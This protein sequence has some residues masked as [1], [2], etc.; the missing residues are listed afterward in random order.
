MVITSALC[1]LDRLKY[2]SKKSKS[3]HSSSTENSTGRYHS[4]RFPCQAI[5]N[6]AHWNLLNTGLCVSRNLLWYLLVASK[7]YTYIYHTINTCSFTV[8]VF[9]CK[10]TGWQC[11]YVCVQENSTLQLQWRPSQMTHCSEP[12]SNTWAN[13]SLLIYKTTVNGQVIVWC[14]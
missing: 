14:S 7:I 5:Y 4:S 13:V 9:V 12:N 10:C 2:E 1:F 8:D 3:N 6:S 11:C